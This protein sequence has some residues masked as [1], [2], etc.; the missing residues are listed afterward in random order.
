MADVPIT[1]ANQTIA[2]PASGTK[3]AQRWSDERIW[4]GKHNYTGGVVS[5]D[6]SS[7]EVTFTEG[8]WRI[9]VKWN[10]FAVT[11]TGYGGSSGTREDAKIKWQILR[12]GS[13]WKAGETGD[14]TTYGNGGADVEYVDLELDA[15]STSR[16]IKFQF[17]DTHNG[18]TGGNHGFRY[19]NMLLTRS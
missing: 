13:S 10:M 1:E 4:L 7:G 11:G 15:T 19:C 18:T 9:D 8:T 6:A 16:I 17:Q 14:W 5:Y 2:T 3:S 12:D